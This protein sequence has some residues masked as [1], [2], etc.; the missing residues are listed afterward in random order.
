MSLLFHITGE[1]PHACPDCD[2]RTADPGSFTRHRKNKHGYVPEP[3]RSKAE[4]LVPPA[5]E[6]RNANLSPDASASTSSSTRTDPTDL[7]LVSS[8]VGDSYTGDKTQP[9]GVL[10]PRRGKML[11]Q[12][13]DP[14]RAHSSQTIISPEAYTSTQQAASPH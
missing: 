8:A 10:S 13:P 1:K 6:R 2:F 4:P 11:R 12:D 14:L 7:M 5:G 9:P 3:R